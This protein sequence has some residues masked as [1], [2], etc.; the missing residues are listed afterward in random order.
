M[1]NKEHFVVY[2]LE[3][4]NYF[5]LK[6]DAKVNAVK[7]GKPLEEM[8]MWYVN[9]INYHRE[10]AITHCQEVP[11]WSNQLQKVT[12]NFELS[13]LCP[14]VVVKKK[15]KTVTDYSEYRKA[16]LKYMNEVKKIQMPALH[17]IEFTE[18]TEKERVRRI[19]ENDSLENIF[20]T[21]NEM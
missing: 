1:S 11:D 7:N 10:K 14:P 19:M 12:A 13:L 6:L 21:A 20:V 15:D 5:H 3:A 18:K 4:L 8:K 2:H 17:R 9:N 16:L